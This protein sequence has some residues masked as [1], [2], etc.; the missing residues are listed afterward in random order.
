M[1][2]FISL[3]ITLELPEALVC[4]VGCDLLQWISVHS[5][6][7]PNQPHQLPPRPQPLLSRLLLD[8][9]HTTFTQAVCLVPVLLSFSI[10]ERPRYR[11]NARSQQWATKPPPLERSAINQSRL[12]SG[13][14]HLL[15]SLSTRCQPRHGHC[16]LL[17]LLLLM[18]PA[19][20]DSSISD[21][22]LHIQATRVSASPLLA[23]TQP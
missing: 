9:L 17:L 1:N 11:P 22:F 14:M 7:G 6:L 5:I 10:S 20:G 13:Y 3:D 18:L 12:Y 4:I 2:A 15:H 21:L 23:L 19:G 16:L 8:T